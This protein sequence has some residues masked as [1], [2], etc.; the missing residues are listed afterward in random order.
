MSVSL[1][2]LEFQPVGILL[3]V[4]RPRVTQPAAVAWK[5]NKTRAASPV[6]YRRAEADSK[7]GDE[8][9]LIVRAQRVSYHAAAGGE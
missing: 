7:K 3:F 9:R 5:Q 4:V 2:P 6:R 8:K 1:R